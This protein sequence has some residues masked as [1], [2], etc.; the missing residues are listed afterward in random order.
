MSAVRFFS[1]FAEL[2]DVSWATIADGEFLKRSGTNIDGVVL[3]KSDV[4][5]SSQ[6]FPPMWFSGFTIVNNTSDLVN[7][8]DIAAGTCRDESDTIDIRTTSTVT[9]RLDAVW[10]AGTNAGGLDTGTAAASTYHIYVIM[11]ADL[12]TDFLFTATYGSPTMPSGF[13]YKRR[14]ASIVRSATTIRRIFQNGDWFMMWTPIGDHTGASNSANQ[15]FN[16]LLAPAVPT[17]M[18]HMTSLMMNFSNNAIACNAAMYDPDASATAATLNASA[19]NI[20]FLSH[21]MIMTNTLSQLSIT[22]G[23]QAG[24]TYSYTGSVLGYLDNRLTTK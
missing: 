14:V 15:S 2:L 5:L 1:K 8:I 24:G 17:G 9:K 7:D 10:A 12:T 11:K 3:T 16:L 13:V 18:K 19:P 22:S 23:V 4:G 21:H 20:G 6:M